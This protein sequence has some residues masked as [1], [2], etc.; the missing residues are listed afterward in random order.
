MSD[1]GLEITM[2][3]PLKWSP[4]DKY[5]VNTQTALVKKPSDHVYN[6]DTTG[7]T[8]RLVKYSL[9]LGLV[10]IVD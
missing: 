1:R 4:S 7:H 8:T 2:L 9:K 10:L 5:E 6:L 3:N